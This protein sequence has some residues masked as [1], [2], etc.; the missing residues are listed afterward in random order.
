[1]LF[2]L[3]SVV[4]KSQ[5][6]NSKNNFKWVLF[7]GEVID[8]MYNVPIYIYIERDIFSDSIILI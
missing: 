1:M 7:G 5:A 6:L 4:Y 2:M 3:Y 8:E